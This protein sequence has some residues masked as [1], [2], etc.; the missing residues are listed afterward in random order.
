MKSGVSNERKERSKFGKMCVDILAGTIAGINV[1]LVGHPFDTLKVRLQTQPSKNPIYSGVV[2]CFKKT[3]KWEGL[4]GLYKGVQSPLIGQ[5]IF[6]ANMFLGFGEGKRFL[7]NNGKKALTNVD[8]FIAG[9]IGWA[10]GSLAECP[11]DF[12][13]TQM[14][15]Q[16]VKSKANPEYVPEFNGFIDCVKKVIKAN[17]LKGAYQGF[18]P[19]LMRNVPG[20]SVHLGSF[21]VIRNYYAKKYNVTVQELPASITMLA[22]S[23][24]GVLFW[25]IFFPFDVVKSTIQGDSPFKEKR[26]Y[27]GMFDAYKQMWAEEGIKRFYKGLVPC[28]LRAIPANAV[29]LLTSSYISEHL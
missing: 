20:G 19:H 3:I 14:Q 22:G 2:D 4:G 12:F 23:I 17:G 21:E 25:I 28:M 27:R 1:T 13:K 24:G 8:Y 29:L 26:K 9:A 10:W 11:I 7:S 18:I 15:I 5:M 6:R 16:I